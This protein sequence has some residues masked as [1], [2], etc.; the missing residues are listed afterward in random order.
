MAIEMSKKELDKFMRDNPESDMARL[1][2]E[3]MDIQD[4]P[5]VAELPVSEL[6]ELDTMTPTED[7]EEMAPMVLEDM[8]E[9]APMPPMPSSSPS[10]VF[11]DFGERRQRKNRCDFDADVLAEYEK[12]TGK[13]FYGP[14]DIKPVGTI[15]DPVQP[16]GNWGLLGRLVSNYFKK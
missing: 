4:E 7:I 5:V 9:M 15:W 1:I 3:Q 8:E 6:P 11:A 13:E 2:K 16:Y 12:L 14:D 10:P